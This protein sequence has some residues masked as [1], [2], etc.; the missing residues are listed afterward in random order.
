MSR[1]NDDDDDDIDDLDS[2]ANINNKQQRAHWYPLVT[3]N[4]QRKFLTV[5]TTTSSNS[6]FI[7]F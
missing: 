3:L 6:C 4:C 7:C 2:M 1:K 5:T